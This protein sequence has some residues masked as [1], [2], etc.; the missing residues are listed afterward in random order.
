MKRAMETD[1]DETLQQIAEVM[2]KILV[3]RHL[4]KLV[5]QVFI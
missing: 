1:K 2:Q 5:F 4:K 3:F